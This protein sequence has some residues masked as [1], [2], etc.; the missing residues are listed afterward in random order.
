MYL[1]TSL[2]IML[3]PAPWPPAKSESWLMNHCR[4][5]QSSILPEQVSNHTCHLN[6]SPLRF[7]FATS[8]QELPDGDCKVDIFYQQVVQSSNSVLFFCLFVC[9]SIQ[10]IIMDSS[11]G[12]VYG[13][14]RKLYIRKKWHKNLAYLLGLGTLWSLLFPYGVHWTW[15]HK[16]HLILIMQ[17]CC[18]HPNLW[19]GSSENTHFRVLGHR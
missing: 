16:S 3:G 12:H 14:K 11:W 18:E 15:S 9:F 2:W 8:I 7:S 19:L 1:V 5:L 4:W 10:L 6:F 17:C 13:L